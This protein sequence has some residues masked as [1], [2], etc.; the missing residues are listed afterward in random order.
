MAES[1]PKKIRPFGQTSDRRNLDSEEDPLVELAR[2]V[3][4]DSGFYGSRA[5]RAKPQREEPI[6]RNAYSAD[7][8]SE[9]LQE[10]ESSFSARAPAPRRTPAPAAPGA[11][12]APES[13]A[14]PPSDGADDL[15]RSIEKQ[16]GEFERR[17]QTRAAAPP[18][19]PEEMPVRP[20]EQRWDEPVHDRVEE[21]AEDDNVAP[22]LDDY[23]LPPEPPEEQEPARS[24]RERILA[25]AREREARDRE[26]REARE[27][28]AREARER[29]L[30]EREARERA[31]AES[32]DRAATEAREREMRDRTLQEARERIA[33]SR[34]PERPDRSA[35]PPQNRPAAR[36]RRLP[37]I[38]PDQ[39]EDAERR[40]AM[41]LPLRR[42]DA[43]VGN[44]R[45]QGASGFVVGAAS[46][47]NDIDREEDAAGP[48]RGE[49]DW[50]SP[51]AD[52]RGELRT[53]FGGLEEV[54]P[55]G[56]GSHVPV[57]HVEAE[58]QGE[59]EPSYSDPA[60]GANWEDPRD[61]ENAAYADQPRVTPTAADSGA[62]QERS[63]GRRSRAG[64]LAAAGVLA[65]VVIGAV[66]AM[67][68]RSGEDVPGGPPPVI[69]APEGDVKVEPP[70]AQAAAEGE[71]AGEAV[72]NRVAGN[73]PAAE[74]QVVDG[75]EEPREI[76]RIVLPPPQENGD[77]A[78]TR[79][80]GDAD[81][82]A[83]ETAVPGQ[84]VG[85]RRVRT[86]VVRPDG[87]IA[88]TQA[89]PAADDAPSPA[90]EQ[91]LA[92]AAQSSSEP[93]VPVRV[94]TTQIDGTGQSQAV[95]P[96]PM[97]AAPAPQPPAETAALA[98][99]PEPP[100]TAAAQSA[101][102]ELR[103][104]PPAEAE[105]AAAPAAAP[106]AATGEG[107]VVQISSQRSMDDA[108]SSWAAVKR[109]YPL[110]LGAMEPNIQQ[111]DLGAKGIYY[112]VRVG[113]WASREEAV[114][115]CESLRA[116][117]GDCLVTR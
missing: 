7:L 103:S 52:Y 89:A 68:V 8:E 117:G 78:L 100:P 64:L 83:A 60:F 110:V 81:A 17:N 18:P 53:T 96:D 6:D 9:L 69:A 36:S 85:P 91:Q 56:R 45:E 2:I 72:Y 57:E 87:T 104:A 111:A 66:A 50:G 75:A 38:I 1:D 22:D 16:L 48:A 101:P 84:D 82:A 62:R 47:W 114:Q 109:R 19:P 27:R 88:E 55:S 71:T 74:E 32:R 10:L 42:R 37:P 14:P 51:S 49:Q 58:M 108:Q 79:P 30:A 105:T 80:V 12:P 5:E 13:I 54:S 116:A 33:G 77:D 29:R 93:M 92:A 11:R 65:V 99:S 46:G 31:A 67:Y 26:A 3:S 98:P 106:P 97:Q 59:L 20:Y 23:A 94:P 34:G 25:E 24:Q 63:E 43:P 76:S 28:E 102:A 4:E 41:R 70:P 115:V 40:G 112:R 95:Q 90:E 44:E 35:Q 107:Y 73:A 15:L 86:Y 21:Q 113:P 61:G 39:D